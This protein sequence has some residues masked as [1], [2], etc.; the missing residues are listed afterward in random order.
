MLTDAT[1]GEP[2][3]QG[4]AKKTFSGGKK[5]ALKKV[6]KLVRKLFAD[7]PRVA[8][9]EQKERPQAILVA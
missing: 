7:F 3:W 6:D 5:S 9:F 2:V 1:S 8:S 4:V